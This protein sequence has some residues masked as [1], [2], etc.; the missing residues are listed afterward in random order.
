MMLKEIYI[1]GAGTNGEQCLINCRRHG[2]AVAAFLD[3]ADGKML[4]NSL[5]V[6]RPEKADRDM[7]VVVTSPNYCVDICLQLEWLGFRN[8]TNLSEFNRTLGIEPDWAGDLLAHRPEYE[9]ARAMLADD[10]SRTVFDAAV[11]FR[12]TLN[13]AWLAAVRSPREHQWFDPE[14]FKP[15]AHVFVDGGAYDGDTTAEFIRQC[16]EYKAALL[17][18]PSEKLASRAKARFGVHRSVLVYQQ[19]LSDAETEGR[20]ENAGLP[21]G[22]VGENGEK[23]KL[24]TLD[25]A[26]DLSPTFLK[27]DVEGCEK[28]A[29]LGA[30]NHIRNG[31]PCIACAVYHRP[32]DL[33]EIP[34][35]ISGMRGDY[36]FY[37]R[38][39]TQFYHETVLYCV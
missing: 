2:I 35:V 17:F 23:I 5:P 33:R 8:I 16:P 38:H 21:G 28:A 18:E 32:G 14:F 36:K 6:L 22:T 34:Q 4:F 10:R 11:M 9:Q 29:L 31:K 20:L 25:K 24:T 1:F 37:L 13:P 7:P 19:G 30:E 39:Y 26:I 12:K 3:N 27:L 15:G